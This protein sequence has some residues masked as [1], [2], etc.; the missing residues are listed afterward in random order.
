MVLR[1]CCFLNVLVAGSLLF[2]APQIVL[3]LPLKV[4]SLLLRCQGHSRTKGVRYEEG[5]VPKEGVTSLSSV[6]FRNTHFMIQT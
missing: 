5:L 4:P 3:L 1:V 6:S 2:F